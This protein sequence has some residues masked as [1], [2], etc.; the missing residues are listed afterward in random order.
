[1]GW[2]SWRGSL[3]L[4][5]LASLLGLGAW[6]WF[7]NAHAEPQVAPA[8]PTQEAAPQPEDPE[9]F[10]PTDETPSSEPDLSFDPLLPK[11]H[12][13]TVLA[14]APTGLV[15]LSGIVVDSFDKQPLPFF[16]LDFEVLGQEEK[17]PIIRLTTDERGRFQAPQSVPVARILTS[18]IDTDAR[19]KFPPPWTLEPHMLGRPLELSIS[20]GPTYRLQIF[21]ENVAPIENIEARIRISSTRTK[22]NHASEWLP[23]RAGE[24]PWVRFGPVPIS[25]DK[26][27]RLEARTLDG[28]WEGGIRASTARGQAPGLTALTLEAR[29][30]IEGRVLDGSGEAVEGMDVVLQGLLSDGRSY[31]RETK[32]DA[33]GHYR[34]GH[35]PGSQ[36]TLSTRSLRYEPWSQVQAV[37]VGQ[38]YSIDARVGLRRI[39]GPIRVRVESESGRYQ[40]RFTLKLTPEPKEDGSP[41][42]G[43]E[44]SGVGEWKEVQGRMVA[45]VEFLELP[46][47][48]YR[49]SIDKQ[50]FFRW[51]P[52]SQKLEPPVEEARI[53]I[54]D[55]VPHTD[56]A[57]RA[58]DRHSGQVIVRGNLQVEF[59]GGGR[60]G[61][62]DFS[63]DITQV[64]VRD[65]PTERKF[66]W[67][68]DVPGYG[69][70]IGNERAFQIEETWKGRTTR[71]AEIE[72]TQGHGEA[73]M[74]FSEQNRRR[75][76]V[77]GVKVL[78][79]GREVGSSGTDGI[80]LVNAP[81]APRLVQF[82]AESLGYPEPTAL[83]GSRK[84]RFVE[85]VIP[86]KSNKGK[87]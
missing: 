1:M 37:V 8:L 61:V 82:Q 9:Y 13:R 53:L 80:C 68:L 59:G 33:A 42:I 11:N 67:R 41:R 47:D 14:P 30:K 32:S 7:L 40:P 84:D 63:P 4:V 34:F 21:P 86:V 79:D 16:R 17:L 24:A 44:R 46:A 2:M 54:M 64:L 36:V 45:I 76:P 60:G 22:D 55:A 57:V 49:L 19:K 71:V 66:S 25:C 43:A 72:L 10:S 26:P 70:A 50:D 77:A 81:F 18:Y 20:S 58:I 39:A 83:Q 85:V 74:F 12:S 3:L 31:T 51:E 29:A 48:L 35:L 38:S 62:R 23:L 52:G 28:L 87:R 75:K 65:F 6:L 5:L 56:L 27:E 73:Y 15:T 69:P 78:H